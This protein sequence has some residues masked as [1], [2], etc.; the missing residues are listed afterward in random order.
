MCDD[1]HLC[2]L[3][4]EVHVGHPPHKIRTCNVTGSPASK[5]HVWEIGGVEHVLPLVESFHLYDRSG[6]AV[7]HNERLQVDQIPAIV[8]LCIQ[9]GL[10]I[11]EYPIRRRTFPVYNV[12]GRM[13][14]FERRFPKYDSPGKDI[15]AYGFWEKRNQSSE[16]KS[17][18]LLADDVQGMFSFE[19]FPQNAYYMGFLFIKYFD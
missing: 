9:A 13:I 14:D 7:S 12:A 18:H 19:N 1:G 8:E 2:R 11:P 3:C 4:G 15:N 10:D 16:N 17:M 6:R 5:E